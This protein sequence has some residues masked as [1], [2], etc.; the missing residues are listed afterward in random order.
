[1]TDRRQMADVVRAL[2]AENIGIAQ[3]NYV[4][5]LQQ[6]AIWRRERKPPIPDNTFSGSCSSEKL[7][8]SQPGAMSWS[9]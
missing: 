3:P 6:D 5:R 7:I 2:E 1:M 8:A 4:F 9:Q